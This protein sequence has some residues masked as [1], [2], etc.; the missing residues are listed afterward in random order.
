MR[1][2]YLIFC[3]AIIM[4]SLLIANV[5][6][7]QERG[8]K[9]M[10][11]TEPNKIVCDSNNIKITVIYDNYSFKGSLETSWGFSCL[12]TGTEKTILFDTGGNGPLLLEN[13]SKLAIVPNEIDLVILSHA[14]WDH[15]NG[16]EMF[17]EKNHN[18]SVFVLES[19]P[20]EFKKMVSS[21]GAEI[22][23]VE[24]HREI[25]KGVFS[26]GQLGTSIK[27]QGLILRTEKGLILITGCAHPGIVEMAGR[28]KDLFNE[29]FLFVMGGFH[30]N[31]M[32]NKEVENIISKLK[33]LNVKYTAPCHCTGD[34]AI[35]LFEKHFGEQYVRIGTGKVIEI[36]ELK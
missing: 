11:E 1:I 34:S 35:S 13:M 2:V 33:S 16:V 7:N 32:S 29:N 25:C 31:A 5:S 21:Y 22:I 27:E 6:I 23:E 12:I 18:V 36:K 4:T 9:Q 3:F 8:E 10:Q 14:H 30:L 17:L 19:F 20:G 26:T 15:V 24:K 28:T